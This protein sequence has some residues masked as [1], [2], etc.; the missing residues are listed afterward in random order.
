MQSPNDPKPSIKIV[1]G[2]VVELDGKAKEDFDLIDAYIA[3]YGIDITRA[4]EVMQMSSKELANKIVDP[5]I[6]R[7][8]IIQ[9][10]TSA[11]PAKINEVVGYMNVVEMMMAVQKMRARRR[12]TT[13][14][15]VTNLRD[16][17]VQIAADA[18]EACFTWV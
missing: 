17:P 16:N 1:A 5:N 3:Q 9:L 7:E 8:E 12:P 13:Q 6:C 2:E 11:T 15:H 14:S 18:A 10:T 4:E